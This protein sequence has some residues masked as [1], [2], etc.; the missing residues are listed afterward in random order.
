MIRRV[1][2]LTG[3][4]RPSPTPATAVLMPTTRECASASAPPE[5]P[6]LSAASVWITSSTSRA[7]APTPPG[8]PRPPQPERAAPGP[9]EL[10]AHEPVRLAQLGGRR[11]G[12]ARAHDRE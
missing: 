12:S 5:L 10:P 8:A 3:T 2:A 1:V 6:G 4:A 9:H 11:R 7:A